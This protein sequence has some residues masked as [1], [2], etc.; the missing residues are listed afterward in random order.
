MGVGNWDQALVWGHLG[1]FFG[2]G[3]H[4]KLC[5][6]TFGENF[7]P[8]W[9]WDQALVLVHFGGEFGGLQAPCS[10]VWALLW[11]AKAAK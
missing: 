10:H 7:G 11:A 3:G 4:T 2:G 8:W 9:E 6:W 1:P 5:F